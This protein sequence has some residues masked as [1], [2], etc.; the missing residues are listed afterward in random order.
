M[1]L[2]TKHQIAIGEERTI[3]DLT[4]EY[5]NHLYYWRTT[6]H[7]DVNGV[8]FNDVDNGLLFQS[9]KMHGCL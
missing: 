5:K 4:V 1:A 8:E 6:K 7:V 9:A 3:A 2:W